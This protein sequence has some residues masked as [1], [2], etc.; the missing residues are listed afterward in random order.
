M[1]ISSVRH[2]SLINCNLKSSKDGR[3]SPTP[4]H[5]HAHN[6][7]VHE[8]KQKSQI[9]CHQSNSPP[10]QLP[11]FCPKRLPH[12]YEAILHVSNG[13]VYLIC[14]NLMLAPPSSLASTFI[15]RQSHNL[16]YMFCGSGQEKTP[17]HM[18]RDF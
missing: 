11:S 8:T 3:H 9:S 16:A 5:L 4:H 1:L 10:P 15:L 7:S 17:T 18:R 14:V 6:S 13:Q 12:K 2:P